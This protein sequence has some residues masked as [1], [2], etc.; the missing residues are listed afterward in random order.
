MFRRSSLFVLASALIAVGCDDANNPAGPS[1]ELPSAQIS[2][3]RYLGGNDDFFFLPPVLP[4]PKGTSNYNAGAFNAKLG[5]TVSV[6]QLAGN[7]INNPAVDCL[8]RTDGKPVLVASFTSSQ[9]QVSASGEQYHVNWKTDDSNLVLDRFY[10]LQ[11]FV[12][13]VRLGFADIDPVSN[14]KDLKNANTGEVIALVDGR[15]LPVKFR[16]ENGALCTNKSDCGEFKVTNS[17]GTFVTNTADAGVRIAAGALPP[18]VSELTLRIERV[19]VGPDNRCHGA[20]SARLWR[21]FEGCYEITSDPDLR[22]FGG[23]VRPPAGGPPAVVAQCVELNPNSP[24]DGPLYDYLQPYKSHNGGE[25]TRLV[26]IGVTFLN[27]DGF[28]GSVAQLAPANPLTRLAS[29]GLRNLGDGFSRV[30]GVRTL[31]AID[32]GLGEEIGPGMAFSRFGGAIGLET[33]TTGD[34]Q[35]TGFGLPVDGSLSVHVRSLHFHS[36]G[37]TDEHPE[38]VTGVPVVFTVTE[39]DGYFSLAQTGAPVRTATVMSGA[40]GIASI[41]FTAASNSATNVVTATSPTFEAEEAVATFAVNGLPPDLVVEN[42]V[43]APLAPTTADPLTWSFTVRNAGQGIAVPSV[44]RIVV[45]LEE[46]GTETLATYDIPVPRLLPGASVGLTTPALAGPHNVGDHSVMVMVNGTEVVVESTADN[47]TDVEDFTIASTDRGSITGRV[48]L[49][50]QEFHP[51]TGATVQLV[52]GN[53]VIATTGSNESLAEYGFTDLAPGTYTL[54][55]THPWAVPTELSRTVTVGEPT[56]VNILM[57]ILVEPQFLSM[58]TGATYQLTTRVPFLVNWSGSNDNASISSSG[59]V[60]AIVGGES[61]TTEAAATMTATANSGVGA[62]NGRAIVNSF[63]FDRFPRALT[64]VWT[65][66]NVAVSYHVEW[67]FGNG[68]TGSSVN[69]GGRPENCGIWSPSGSRDVTGTSTDISF[70]GAQPGRWR[71]T[72]TLDC[73]SVL[74][75]S[76]WVYFGFN[77]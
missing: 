52:Q 47:N 38:E 13:S 70:V 73:G 51:L 64:L 1:T 44:T 28:A 68:G 53:Q 56:S 32:L 2:D 75:P 76:P 43:R 58:Q 50:G 26:N 23:F 72:A 59:L 8:L 71:V 37:E 6:C 24:I 69:C 31:N 22:P 29:A 48:M 11:V 62:P 54:R 25:L 3:G 12:G 19:T 49:N 27:C 10:R 55:A 34:D 30:F 17:G 39:G 77:K 61:I 4:D 5:P 67:D 66:V 16:I 35:S 41:G 60:T 65:P 46:E 21:E 36:H 57:P 14:G 42:L 45:S 15:T 18:G 40:N 33:E 7:P 74:E 63:Q 9:V 20:A